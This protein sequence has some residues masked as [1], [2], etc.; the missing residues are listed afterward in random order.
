MMTYSIAQARQAIEHLIAG[1]HDQGGNSILDAAKQGCTILAWLE[2]R[3]ELVK[4]VERLYRERPDLVEL[5][6]TWPE[7][8]IVDVRDMFLNGSGIE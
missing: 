8:Q 7:A 2:R 3:Q 5:F 4:A 6:R 1:Y